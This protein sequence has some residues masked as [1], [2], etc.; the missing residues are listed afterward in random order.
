MHV[1][2]LQVIVGPGINIIRVSIGRNALQ[3]VERIRTKLL[4]VGP[5][6][7]IILVSIGKSVP[8]AD[9]IRTKHIIRCQNISIITTITG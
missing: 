9:V 8:F 5:G 6:T 1:E 4:I 2:E 7:S 3:D